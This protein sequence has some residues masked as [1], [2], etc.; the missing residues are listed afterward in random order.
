MG[1]GH[2]QKTTGNGTSRIQPTARDANTSSVANTSFVQNVQNETEYAKQATGSN[3]ITPRLLTKEEISKLGPSRPRRQ[4]NVRN[5]C[6][7]QLRCDHPEFLGANKYTFTVEGIQSGPTLRKIE[8]VLQEFLLPLKCRNL[9]VLP[10]E[11]GAEVTFDSRSKWHRAENY[12]ESLE[13]AENFLRNLHALGL[14]N[15]MIDLSNSSSVLSIL[16]EPSWRCDPYPDDT[17]TMNR[18]DCIE[19]LVGQG[20]SESA[21]KIFSDLSTWCEKQ[22]LP[23]CLNDQQ[24]SLFVLLKQPKAQ[25]L[26]GFTTGLCGI[27]ES[28]R[29]AV[30]TGKMVL[31]ELLSLENNTEA[32]LDRHLQVFKAI[33]AQTK[34]PKAAICELLDRSKTARGA[35]L[36]NQKARQLLL[37][38]DPDI[39][40]VFGQN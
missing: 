3:T 14:D 20:H 32:I 27:C 22:F 40:K 39:A 26:R 7:G 37:M 1:Q 16:R 5:I 9:T 23:T 12:K 28:Y 34:D 8:K 38:V 6:F 2:V 31:R 35:I 24:R 25:R 11:H 13:Q 33:A 17:E 21:Y 36:Q 15:F 18:L 10:T 4:V 30:Q 29:H 19:E